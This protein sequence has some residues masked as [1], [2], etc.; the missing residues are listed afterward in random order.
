MNKTIENRILA[1]AGILQAA[2]LV[3]ELAT[4]G[5][6]NPAAFKS[7]IESIYKLDAANVLDIYDNQIKNLE[8][9]LATFEKIMNKDKKIFQKQ[10][11]RIFFNLVHLQ[12]KVSKQKKM[13]DALRTRIEKAVSQTE[14][15]QN[16]V[17]PNILA[18]LADGYTEMIGQFNFRIMIQGNKQYLTQID[19]L[20]KIRALLLAGLRSAVLWDQLGGSRWN[21]LFQ[22]VKYLEG[23]RGLL[24]R[25]P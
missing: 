22:R 2:D 7:S 6:C 23:V 15:F 21:I 19:I 17:H 25:I 5:D 14:Y 16:T 8:L 3:N 12:K 1:L 24:A 20:H 13:L 4:H 10:I 9:G 18:N 11:V